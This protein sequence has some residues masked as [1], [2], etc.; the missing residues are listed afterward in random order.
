[1]AVLKQRST[2]AARPQAWV[3]TEAL[4]KPQERIVP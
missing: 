3:E 4:K 1:M 2:A